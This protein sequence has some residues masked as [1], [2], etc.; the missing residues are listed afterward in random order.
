MRLLTSKA[1]VHYRGLVLAGIDTMQ[2]EAL[3]EVLT[4]F[5]NCLV[6]R[7]SILRSAVRV[8]VSYRICF[9]GQ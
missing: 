2:S 1:V 5:D 4:L 9:Y 8:Y 3:L 6:L 7:Y